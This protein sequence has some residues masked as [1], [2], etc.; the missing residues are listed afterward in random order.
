[1]NSY[2]IKST[3]EV[4]RRKDVVIC[5]GGP[6]GIAAAISAAREGA[7]VLVLEKNAFLGGAG[8]ASRVSIFAYGFHDKERYIIG[9]IFKEMRQRLFER[10]ALIKTKRRGWEP[11]NPFEYKILLDEMMAENNVEVLYHSSVTN[12]IMEGDKIK[13]AI[14]STKEGHKAI[15]GKIFV[16]TTGDADIA[17]MSGAPYDKGRIEDAAMQPMTMMYLIGGVDWKKVGSVKERGAWKDD[18]GRDY[19]NATGY[20]EFA[21]QAVKDGKWNLPYYGLSSVYTIPWLDGVAGINFGRVLGKN[22]LNCFDLSSAEVEGRMQMKY[23]IDFLKEY[24]P[25]FEHSHIISGPCGIGVR[26]TR[27]IKGKYILSEDDVKNLVQF[28]D[29]I[30]QSCYMIDVH[31]PDGETT[32]LHKLPKGTHHDIPYRCLLPIG[33]SN[34]LVAGRCASADQAAMGAI[35]VQP[36]CMA[37]GQG[38]GVAAALCAKRSVKPEDL[39]INLLQEKL[40]GQSAI[41]E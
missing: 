15:E 24:V 31:S 34:L 11:Y 23:G 3:A 29:V 36:T 40:R 1:M 16:D 14:I 32:Y 30:A 4:V 19:L 2:E 17:A 7:K 41:L 18:S 20:G 37:M 8:T 13:A 12:I 28:D 21:R 35:R 9:G 25:G 38:A 39:C 6:A 33:V 22:G 5:G 27:R 26:E 10:D